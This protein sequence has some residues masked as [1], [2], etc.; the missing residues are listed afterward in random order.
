MEVDCPAVTVASIGDAGISRRHAKI[1]GATTGEEE[2]EEDRGVSTGRDVV[3][4][5]SR[6]HTKRSGERTGAE[7]NCVAPSA[8]STGKGGASRRHL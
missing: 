3:D 1:S 5:V 8:A 4:V 2:G 6:A 7:G